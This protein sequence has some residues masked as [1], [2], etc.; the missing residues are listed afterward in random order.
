M[1]ARSFRSAS[2]FLATCALPAIAPAQQPMQLTAMDYIEIQ[3][4]VAKCA[5]A[6][7]TCS[8]NG[9]DYADLYTEDGIFQPDVGGRAIPPIQGREALARVSG[10]GTSNCENVPW[11]EQGIRHIYTN[12]II[13]PSPDGATGTVDMLMI[14]IDGDPE[15]ILHDG[16]YDDVYVKT[17]QGWRF[18]KRTH[19]AL[20]NAGQPINRPATAAPGASPQG[21]RQ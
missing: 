5:R 20:L 14:G 18:A 11:I 12:H 7:D 8:N 17:P 10:G 6:I 19:H 1:T 13:T 2:I 16:Y 9:Y 3:Q 4:L 15:K 21:G